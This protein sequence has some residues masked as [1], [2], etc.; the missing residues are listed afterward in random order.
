MSCLHEFSLRMHTLV[1]KHASPASKLCSQDMRIACRHV[2]P[3]WIL[4]PNAYFGLQACFA[5]KQTMLAG[6]EDSM[7]C[8]HVRPAC[9][10]TL[11]RPP[12]VCGRTLSRRASLQ[13]R[14]AAVPYPGLRPP[15]MGARTSFLFGEFLPNLK[16]EISPQ[17]FNFRNKI[18]QLYAKWGKI[19][20]DWL[21]EKS[22]DPLYST[23]LKIF[24]KKK[25]F[26][27]SEAPK[28]LYSS[29]SFIVSALIT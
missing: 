10:R 8:S 27:K 23:F 13:G 2:L 7:L 12:A 22:R 14:P 28:A 25:I 3:A 24:T 21:T 9:G 29:H 19:V 26:L 6:Y 17:S 5:R 4:S 1:C 15:A 20:S 18:T 16:N 11:S